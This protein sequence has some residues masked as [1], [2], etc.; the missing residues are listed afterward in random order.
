MNYGGSNTLKI[1]TSPIQKETKPDVHNI[2]NTLWLSRCF[3]SDFFRHNAT[4]FEV[5][6]I[7]LTDLPFVCF[8]ILQHNGCHK[9]L[10]GPPFTFFGTVTLFKNLIFSDF[11]LKSP[12]GPPLTFFIFCDQL[13]FHK[14]QSVHPFTILSLRYSADFGRSRLVGFKRVSC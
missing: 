7:P 3:H 1:R 4:F 6:W 10:R 12:K 9:I 2:G 11:F 13:E 8:D 14:A 5:F